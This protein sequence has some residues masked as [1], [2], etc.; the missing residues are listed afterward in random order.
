MCK[1]QSLPSYHTRN[2]LDKSCH[3]ATCRSPF[4]WIG[5]LC[6]T[7][8]TAFNRRQQRYH[9]RSFHCFAI[10]PHRTSHLAKHNDLDRPFYLLWKFLHKQNCH[11]VLLFLNHA[12]CHLTT[13]RSISIAVRGRCTRQ[14]REPD[15]P[16]SRQCTNL[17]LH[18]GIYRVHLLFHPICLQCMKRHR[19]ISRFLFHVEWKRD[20]LSYRK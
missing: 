11:T 14:I 8:H 12:A 3:L 16:W 6:T 18:V 13:S 17:H 20:D 1:F 5:C 4:H 15:H 2:S 9:S 7:L 19:P 10:D